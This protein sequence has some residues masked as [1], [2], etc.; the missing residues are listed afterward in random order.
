LHRSLVAGMFLICFALLAHLPAAAEVKDCGLKGFA[1]IDLAGAT[2]G[3]LLVP[4]TI[5]DTRAY[6]V[7][8]MATPFSSVTQDAVD[9]L[10]LQVKPMTIPFGESADKN[11]VQH[12]ATAMQFEFGGVW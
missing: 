4:V 7:L 3:Y 10:S 11:P 12:M 2:D 1:S 8:N 9:S 5:Q 6:M